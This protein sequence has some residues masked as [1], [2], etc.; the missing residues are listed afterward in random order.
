MEVPE[1]PQSRH[2]RLVGRGART[3]LGHDV[4]EGDAPPRGPAPTPVGEAAAPP[5]GPREPREGERE[6]DSRTELKSSSRACSSN[7]GAGV[8]YTRSDVLFFMVAGFLLFYFK[9]YPDLVYNTAHF[10][11]IKSRVLQLA[12]E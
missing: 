10:D 11:L 6:G 9:I 2:A 5:S 7:A 12:S 4:H 3:P 8:F 1:A